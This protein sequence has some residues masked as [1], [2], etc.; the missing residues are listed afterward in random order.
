MNYTLESISEIQ[1]EI[2]PLFQS[3]WDEVDFLADH[4]PL[5]PDWDTVFRLEEAGMFRTYTM[6]SEDGK[7]VGYV[8]VL[9]QPL[10]H[11]RG[12]YNASVDNAFVY[13]EQRGNFKEFLNIIEEDLKEQKVNS[14]TFNLKNWDKKG[15]FFEKIGYTHIENVYIKVMN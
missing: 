11:A 13:P 14:F 6:R 7:L 12:Y 2:F 8:C 3:A 15:E 4:T 10:L 9:V 5:D 1:E